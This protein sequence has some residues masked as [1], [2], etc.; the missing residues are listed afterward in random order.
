VDKGNVEAKTLGSESGDAARFMNVIPTRQNGKIRMNL[1]TKYQGSSWF[2]EYGLPVSKGFAVDTPE[3][4]SWKACDKIG[5][6]MWSSRAQVNAG[7]RGKRAAS[8]PIQEQ[9]RSQGVCRKRGWGQRTGDYQK[10]TSAS[11]QDPG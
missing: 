7:G 11:N 3:G 5:G 8:S 6:D 2:A 9:R 10:I 1:P 4:S